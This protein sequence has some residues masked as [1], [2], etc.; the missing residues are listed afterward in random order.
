MQMP[1]GIIADKI[2]HNNLIAA[3]GCVLVAAGFGL[4]GIPVL[5]AA[6]VGLGNG[7]FHI[8]GG[9]DILNISEKKSAALGIFVSP[10]AFGVFL[11]T[12]LG[13]SGFSVSVPILV[14]LIFISI[15]IIFMKS[16]R[17]DL[18]VSNASFDP[19]I[20]PKLIIS[21]V[22][23]FLVVCLRSYTGLAVDFPWKG[24]GFLGV[25]LVCASAFGKTL[26]GFLFDRFG[27]FK[28]VILSLGIASV[29]FLFPQNPVAGVSAILLFNMTM[30]VTLWFM[31]KIIPGAKGFS[32]GLLTFALFLGFLP[33]Y[34]GA[35]APPFW[36]FAPLSAAA[37]VLLM[38][39]ITK[40]SR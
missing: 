8:G 3:A 2:N 21:V 22:C 4:T 33:V 16:V 12:L 29:L 1:V 37:L 27:A 23:L 18:N 17:G 6:V 7:M 5:A 28:T 10:G 15:L 34:L 24:F 26:G 30:P 19:Y 32:F 14:S 13:R 40:Y 31:A 20:P 36:V 25:A 11:G 39:G 9:I 35:A 38:F